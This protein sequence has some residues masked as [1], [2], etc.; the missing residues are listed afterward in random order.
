M[1]LSCEAVPASR[2]GVAQL[3]LCGELNYETVPALIAHLVAAERCGPGLVVLDLHN[4]TG[5][6]AVGLRSLLDA[7]RRAHVHH[8]RFAVTGADHEIRRTLRLTSLDQ[9]IEVLPD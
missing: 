4:L 8:R 7:A 9:A 5:I 3:E 1:Q 2:P 6:D